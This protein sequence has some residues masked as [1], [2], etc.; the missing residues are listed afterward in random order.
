MGTVI[1]GYSAEVI[2]KYEIKSVIFGRPNQDTE[3]K[4][5]CKEMRSKGFTVKTITYTD[6]R[7]VEARREKWA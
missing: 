1:T 6:L 5:W 3:W 7:A 4:A 2:A